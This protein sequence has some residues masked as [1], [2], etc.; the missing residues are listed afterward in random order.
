MRIPRTL[1]MTALLTLAGHA[2]AA[3]PPGP[4]VVELFTSQGCNSCPPADALLGE[5]AQRPDVL[6][7][8]MHITYWNDLGWKDPF[9]QVQF[10]QRQRR[11]AQQLAQRSPYTPQMVVNGA[12][13]V[14]GSQRG[15]VE[16]LLQKASHSALIAVERQDAQLVLTLPALEHPCDC[17]LAVFGVQAEARTPVG[18]GENA[19]KQLRE[20]QIVRSLESTGRWNG[21]ARVMR[22]PAGKAQADVTGFA[23]LAQERV[24]LRVVGAGRL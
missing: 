6:A 17:I 23:V 9:A 3:P 15:A 11:Y 5:L 18:R 2:S 10:D 7:L 24:S 16:R 8:A 19:G 22:V 21:E 20:F 12:S 14:V 13:D 1:L 4:I